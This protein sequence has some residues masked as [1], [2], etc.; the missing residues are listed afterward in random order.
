P[1]LGIADFTGGHKRLHRLDQ[2]ILQ[3]IFA[4]DY[5][6]DHARTI[7]MQLRPHLDDQP[8]DIRCGRS[9]GHRFHLASRIIE[10]LVYGSFSM[11]ALAATLSPWGR[12]RRGDALPQ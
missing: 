8:L 2:G 5:R 3:H 11:P 7:A 4:V 9:F 12:G 1:T 10:S 6:A